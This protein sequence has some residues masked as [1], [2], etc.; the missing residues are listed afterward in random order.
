MFLKNVYLC[1]WITLPDMFLYVLLF[2]SLFLMYILRDVFFVCDHSSWPFFYMYCL[3]HTI[4]F[5]NAKP[6]I[7][8]GYST[9]N[10]C[11]SIESTQNTTATVAFRA[12]LTYSTAENILVFRFLLRD[13][14]TFVALTMFI[15][16][17]F[18]S[19]VIAK[20]RVYLSFCSTIVMFFAFLI[21]YQ[22]FWHVLSPTCRT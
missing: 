13:P 16:F 1:F 7:G 11:L 18:L 17:F 8:F 21:Q 14:T 12:N 20:Q 22:H 3:D 5:E 9:S 2:V 6:C 19:M 15:F 4:F 10:G